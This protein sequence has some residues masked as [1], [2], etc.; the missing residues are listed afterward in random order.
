LLF[1]SVFWDIPKFPN[2]IKK[3]IW[4][5]WTPIKKGNQSFGNF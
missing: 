3:N 2:T 4:I 5:F 1:S